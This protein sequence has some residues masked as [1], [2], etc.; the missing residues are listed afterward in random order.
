[1]ALGR[2]AGCLS[3]ADSEENEFEGAGGGKDW[4]GLGGTRKGS[5]ENWLKK[6]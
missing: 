2:F 5:I 6:L 3:V 1:M 4:L